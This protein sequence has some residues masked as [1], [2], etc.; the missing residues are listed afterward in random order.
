MGESSDSSDDNE[1]EDV[2]ERIASMWK[3]IP[4]QNYRQDEVSSND[5]MK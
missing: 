2:W 5:E 4:K 3:A 1:D